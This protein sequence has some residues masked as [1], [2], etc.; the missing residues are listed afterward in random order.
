MELV[1]IE[2]FSRRPGVDL[3]TFRKQAA[4]GQEGWDSGFGEDRLVLG[5][6]RTWRLGPEPEYMAVWHS[7]AAG[8]ERDGVGA[9]VR[10][11]VRGQALGLE[12]GKNKTVEVRLQPIG[13]LNRWRAGITNLLKCPERFFTFGK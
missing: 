13:R 10:F 5:L 7:P 4:Q 1:Y 9:G 3:E 6:A 8:F 11:L 12:F 2:Y